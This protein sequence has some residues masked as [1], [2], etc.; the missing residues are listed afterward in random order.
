MFLTLTG[1]TG[2]YASRALL[3]K[4]SGGAGGRG[5]GVKKVFEE[6]RENETHIFSTVITR[7][8][9]TRNNNSYFMRTFPNLFSQPPP[10]HEA[11]SQAASCAVVNPPVAETART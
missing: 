3:A 4:Y 8:E 11:H 7:S 5:G 9:G 6:T 1:S 2:P 10:P